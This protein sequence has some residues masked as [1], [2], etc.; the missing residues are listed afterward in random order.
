MLILHGDDLVKS[1][2]ALTDQ[3][4]QAKEEDQEIISLLGKSLEL[5]SL[6]QALESNSLFGKKKLVVIEN[7]FSL[8]KSR[9]KDK[10]LTYLKNQSTISNQQLTIKLVIWEEKQIDGRLLKSFSK[11][12]VKSFKLP[13]VIFKFLDFLEPN[14]PKSTLSL[15]HQILKTENPEM[16]FYM[17]ARRVREL[18]IAKDLGK[19]G[20]TKCAPWQ[21]SRLLSQANKFSL[22]ELLKIHRDLL[23]IDWQV[24]TGRTGLSLETLL[25]LLIADL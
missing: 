3:K 17:V 19:V 4:Q 13:T 9:T 24:K 14:N 7:L 1:R 15:F 5:S 25:D 21:Q 20:L 16:V 10:V 6:V 23:K 2:E 11:A 12:K 18:I 22:E 8:P